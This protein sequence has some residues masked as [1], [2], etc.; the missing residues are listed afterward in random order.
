MGAGTNVLLQEKLRR[1]SKRK[2]FG[3]RNGEGFLATVTTP[4]LIY[5]KLP[6]QWIPG[7]SCVGLNRLYREQEK[8]FPTGAKAQKA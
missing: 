6:A 5:S 7:V 4:C 3:H 1:L 2:N 8:V